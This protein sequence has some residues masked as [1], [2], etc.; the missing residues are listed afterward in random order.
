MTDYCLDFV[1]QSCVSRRLHLNFN[2]NAQ[3]AMTSPINKA[4]DVTKDMMMSSNKS[5]DV[6]KSFITSSNRS[7][8]SVTKLAMMS[9]NVNTSDVTHRAM[10]SANKSDV[11]IVTHLQYNRLAI[12]VK[13]INSWAGPMQVNINYCRFGIDENSL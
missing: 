9:S 8:D 13:L 12:L 10:T 11:T 3:K 7:S 2:N 1:Y 6:T 5:Y 4:Y